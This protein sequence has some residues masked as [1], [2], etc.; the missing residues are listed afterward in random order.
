M[1]EGHLIFDTLPVQTLLGPKHHESHVGGELVF[2][3]FV[4]PLHHLP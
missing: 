4:G 1:F 2:E 3:H